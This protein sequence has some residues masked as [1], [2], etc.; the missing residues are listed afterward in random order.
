MENKQQ[1]AVKYRG[2]TLIELL[3]VLA[4]IGILVTIGLVSLQGTREK[5]RDAQR[6]ADLSQMR[7]GL[8]LYFHDHEQYPTPASSSGGGPDIGSEPADGSIFSQNGNPLYPGYVSKVF[9]DPINS[10]QTALYYAYDT[11]ENIRHANYVL[12]YHR[13]GTDKLWFYYYST[14]IYGEGVSCPTLP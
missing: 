6:A 1:S 10:T 5:A 8:A 3:V 2:Y 7:L 9:T 12:C 11:N 4:I 13:E 14:G